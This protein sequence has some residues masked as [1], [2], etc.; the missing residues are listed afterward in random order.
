MADLGGWAKVEKELYGPKGLWTSIFTAEAECPSVGEVTGRWPQAALKSSG[1]ASDLVLRGTTLSYLGVM[2]VLP[3]AALGRRGGAAGRRRVLGGGSRPV[4]L[5]RAQADVRHGARDGAGQRRDRH[6]DRL[7]PGALRLPRRRLVN[8][9]IDL[10]FAVPTVVTGVM[11]VVLFGPSSVLGT[12]LGR[13]GWGVIYQQPGIV[14]ALVVRDLSVR[15]PER[16]A[17]ADGAG[18]GRGRGGGDARGGRVDDL[19]PGHAAGAL[20]VD[21]DRD[22]AV[23]RRA[24]GEFGS[25]VMVAGNQPLATKTAPLYIFGEIESGNRHGA[26]VVSAVLLAGSLADPGRL[27][28]DSAAMGGEPWPL[29][30]CDVDSRPASVAVR[31]A[32]CLADR[33]LALDRRGARLVRLADPGAEPGARAAGVAGGL[34]PFFETLATPEVRRAFGLTLGITA[35]G[36]GGQHG[37]RRGARAGA[38]P[39][40]VLGA[41]A[42]RRRGRPAVRR[43]ADRRRAD[44]GR[45]LRA[46]GLA[47]PLARS[48]RG[49]GWSTRCRG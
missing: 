27:E 42:G 22:G 11:L 13:Y 36:D 43:L 16:A 12:I 23:V 18:S 39:A 38:G 9:L 15:D 4:R 20:A 2:V 17:G 29:I 7:G 8:A 28:P 37:L 32:P 33:P 6:G 24:L 3:L 26:L 44:A 5:A 1:G 25:V 14:L 46:G 48:Q 41:S 35:A 34:R 19:P 40:A 30:S 47:R 10:P 49:S 45:P 21:P 31:R